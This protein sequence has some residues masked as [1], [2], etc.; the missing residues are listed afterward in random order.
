VGEKLNPRPNPI[1]CGSGSG[2]TRGFKI[3]PEPAPVG[4]KTR[5]L[6]ETRTRIAIPTFAAVHT[7]TTV[8]KENSSHAAVHFTKILQNVDPMVFFIICEHDDF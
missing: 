2:S 1:L 8:N 4:L 7:A 5:G 3:Q 6:P